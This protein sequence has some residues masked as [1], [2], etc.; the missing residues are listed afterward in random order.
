MIFVLD[1]DDGA[2]TAFSNAA[3][4]SAHCKA[5]DV[6][7]GF[8]RFFAEDGSPLEARF[9][10]MSPPGRPAEIP[11][12]YVLQRAM[13]GRWLQEHLERVTAVKGCGLA[14]I[15]ELVETLKINRG[16]RVVRDSGGGPSR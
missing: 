12:A 11:V 7:D 9:E 14:T 15:E 3:E 1:T 6:E 10:R 5:V 13:S 4:A 2:L 16:K 8:W